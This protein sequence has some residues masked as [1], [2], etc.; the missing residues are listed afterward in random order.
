MNLVLAI[1]WLAGGVALIAWHGAT[2]APVGQLRV[3]GHP[4]SMGWLMV[5]MSVYNLIRWWALRRDR[6]LR[7]RPEAPRS[8]EARD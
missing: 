4:L 8:P 1:L 5:L 3:G 6:R 7:Y 2:G